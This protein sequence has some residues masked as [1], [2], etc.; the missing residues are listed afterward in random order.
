MDGIGIRAKRRLFVG[1]LI[2]AINAGFYVSGVFDGSAFFLITW[3]AVLG[4]GL[5]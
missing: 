1:A 3:I 2:T 4:L 5:R